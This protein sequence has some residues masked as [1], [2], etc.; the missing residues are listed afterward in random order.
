MIMSFLKKGIFLLVF[1]LLFSG[2]NSNKQ[3]NRLIGLWTVVDVKTEFDEGKVNPSTLQQVAELERLT[4]L[5]FENDTLLIINVDNSKF[6]AFYTFDTK[7]A[8]IF[9]SFDARGINMN[10]MGVFRND[11]IVSLSETPVGKI[12]VLYTKA[13]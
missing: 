12:L 13:K 7:S 9:Y 2:C 6:N 4:T 10:E 3:S 5:S 8:K 11:T 1:A